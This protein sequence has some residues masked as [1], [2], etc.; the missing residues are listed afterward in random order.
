MLAFYEC[1][2]LRSVVLDSVQTL[3]PLCLLGTA[4]ETMRLPRSSHVPL[5]D[6]GVGQKY[7]NILIIPDGTSKVTKEQVPKETD[8]VVVPSSVE[9][10]SDDAFRECQ[11]LRRVVF[12]N[13]SRLEKIG[14]TCF[15]N[16]GLEEIVIPASVKVIKS[17][18]FCNCAKLK[19]VRVER[20]S[21]LE[22]VEESAFA[23]TRLQHQVCFPPDALVSEAAF[24]GSM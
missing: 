14:N 23:G 10:L 5:A 13:G 19:K 4:P 9:E 20:G 22:R 15:R 16:S 7:G 17:G 1:K 6:L 12:Q 21:C 11:K 24:L 18:A 2:Q 3:D 8:V